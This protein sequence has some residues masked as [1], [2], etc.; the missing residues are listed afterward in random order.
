MKPGSNSPAA[1]AAAG[2][3]DRPILQGATTRH[4]RGTWLG[5]HTRSVR[6]STHL[7]GG[8][9]HQ[10]TRTQTCSRY[11]VCTSLRSQREGH[12]HDR[13]LTGCQRQEVVS[14]ST[15]VEFRAR[16]VLIQRAHTGLRLDTA[17]SPRRQGFASDSASGP[18]E[19]RRLTSAG[20][21]SQRARRTHLHRQRLQQ[22]PRE[23]KGAWKWFTHSRRRSPGLPSSRLTS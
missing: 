14:I 4:A 2:H 23:C 5:N 12:T 20:G 1:R 6:N 16:P 17:A 19:T 21:S 15:R 7:L 11:D 9:P 13:P 22:L 18:R 10:T 8:L 3:V